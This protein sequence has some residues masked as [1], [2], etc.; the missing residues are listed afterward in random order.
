MNII[1]N[2]IFDWASI[3]QAEC[4]QLT[5]EGVLMEQY[6]KDLAAWEMLQGPPACQRSRRKAAFLVK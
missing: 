2:E 5:D 6:E 4:L 3:L 1:E